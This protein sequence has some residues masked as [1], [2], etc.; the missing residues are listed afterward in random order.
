M[1]DFVTLSLSILDIFCG[2]SK[3]RRLISQIMDKL[4]H[5]CKT[6]GCTTLADLLDVIRPC[7]PFVSQAYGMSI[8]SLACSSFWHRDR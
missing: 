1:M 4:E 3:L 2:I 5:Q 7:L 6:G 8:V